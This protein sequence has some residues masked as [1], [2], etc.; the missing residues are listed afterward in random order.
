MSHAGEAVLVL[1]SSFV[2]DDRIIGSPQDL[3]ERFTPLLSR[4]SHKISQAKAQRGD[5]ALFAICFP[6]WKRD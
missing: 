4:D 2:R 1:A 5:E 6:G 3:G